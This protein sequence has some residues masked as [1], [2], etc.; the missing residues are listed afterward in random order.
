MATVVETPGD[1]QYKKVVRYYGGSSKI[2][3]KLGLTRQA[4]HA[5][6]VRGRIPARWQLEIQRDSQGELEADR[7]AIKEARSM[8]SYLQST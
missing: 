8:A 4:V 2:A 1:M 5:W 6:K 7:N 3:Q